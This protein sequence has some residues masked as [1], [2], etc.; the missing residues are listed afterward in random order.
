M[1]KTTLLFVML[2]LLTPCNL[3]AQKKKFKLKIEHNGV[4]EIGVIY[5]N[6]W[7]DLEGVVFNI[8]YDEL[9]RIG[10]IEL[11]LKIT[12]FKKNFLA[13]DVEYV[14]GE[15]TINVDKLYIGF[16]PT[17]GHLLKV[18]YMKK[19]FG[20]E[21]FT[22]K[23]NKLFINHSAFHHYIKS[24][25]VLGEDLSLQ[26]RLRKK[27]QKSNLTLISYFAADASYKRYIALN[28][29]IEFKPGKISASCM[30]IFQKRAEKEYHTVMSAISYEQ[31]HKVITTDF[32]LTGGIDPNATRLEYIM[33]NGRNVYF[34]G[35]RL[36]Q[37]YHIPL[38]FN[39]ISKMTPLWETDLYVLDY[40]TGKK[41]WQF[42]PG[43]NLFFG[44]KEITR[45]MFS[46]DLQYSTN[47][48]DHNNFSRHQIGYLGQLKF[49]W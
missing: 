43:L 41:I 19:P 26:Y 16:K 1:R 45:F 23:V 20:I 36:L 9:E 5:N 28:G 4:A 2:L 17:K 27:Q 25:Y 11:D 15:P 21:E 38:K 12:P 6:R 34:I 40:R 8:Q 46:T 13:F 48:P 35:G 14:L 18:G 3:T 33:D 10:T 29:N 32:E 7:K 44:K 49:V 24:L 42:R 39:F 22:G 30:Y 47:A 37:A 31:K